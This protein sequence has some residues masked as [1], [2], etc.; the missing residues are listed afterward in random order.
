MQWEWKY[1]CAAKNTTIHKVFNI[2]ISIWID[3]M[4]PKNKLV[5]SQG[6]HFIQNQLRWGF[7]S[8]Q[9]LFF[10]WYKKK[11]QNMPTRFFVC[12]FLT[13]ITQAVV[14]QTQ[15]WFT[16]WAKPQIYSWARFEKQ[17]LFGFPFPL[18]ALSTHRCK[19][20]LGRTRQQSAARWKIKLCKLQ[21]PRLP[22][23]TY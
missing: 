21:P 15:R 22:V 20:K 10:G 23:H 3:L 14:Q 1:G 9:S 13:V 4:V 2:G 17:M 19:H 18:R 6:H 5:S 12:F 16:P 8:H 11:K 7:R